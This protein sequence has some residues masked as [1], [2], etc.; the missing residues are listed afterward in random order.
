MKNKKEEKDKK[1]IKFIPKI[2][3]GETKIYTNLA[4]GAVYCGT[5]PPLGFKELKNDKS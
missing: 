4:T 2:K 1:N 5:N 3:K